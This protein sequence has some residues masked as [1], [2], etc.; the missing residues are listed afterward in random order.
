MAAGTGGHIFP[1]LAVAKQITKSLQNSSFLFWGDASRL[2]AK[3]IPAAGYPIKFLNVDQW[4]GQSKLKKF[5]ALAGVGLSFLKVLVES[6]YHRPDALISVGGY[7][8]VPVALAA[9][10]RNVPIFLI[11]PNSVSGVANVLVSKWAVEAYVSPALPE[12]SKLKCEMVKTGNPVREDLQTLTIKNEVK[13]ILVL[14]GSQGARLLAQGSVQAALEMKSKGLKLH[15][16]IQAGEKNFS[17]INEM[18]TKLQLG[19]TVVV[20][21]FI[22]DVAKAYIDNDLLISRAGATTLAEMAVVGIPSILVPFPHAAD[23]HQRVNARALEKVGAALMVDEVD[24]NFEKNL[25]ASVR[26]LCEGESGFQKRTA[27]H[28]RLR[29]FARPMASQEISV[30]IMNYPQVGKA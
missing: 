24:P 28:L 14:G 17:E 23:D 2:E 25:S 9:K 5:I 20:V 11:E 10:I 1:G 29:D 13:K 15:W 3:L 16:T 26:D 12:S 7:V 21:A 22:Q 27:M 19:E 6:F 18:V 4:K 30:R 8:S